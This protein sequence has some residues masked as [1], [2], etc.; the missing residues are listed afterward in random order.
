[1]DGLPTRRPQL[2]SVSSLGSIVSYQ[3]CSS[4]SKARALDSVVLWLKDFLRP[5]FL[6]FL[7]PMAVTRNPVT[8]ESYYLLSPR[9]QLNSKTLRQST[10]YFPSPEERLPQPS[11]R[12]T[13]QWPQMPNLKSNGPVDRT[14]TKPQVQLP[15]EIRQPSWPSSITVYTGRE[16]RAPS[17]RLQSLLSGCKV[18]KESG[19]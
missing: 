7:I 18:P 19:E 13:C 11:K 15:S 5:I 10:P 3:C 14:Q 12:A 17:P 2:T 4:T 6:L 9:V 1:M 16:H 8:L